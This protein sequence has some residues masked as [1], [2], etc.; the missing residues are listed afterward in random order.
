[1]SAP[2]DHSTANIADQVDKG[3]KVESITRPSEPDEL[4]R[5]QMSAYVDFV[6]G[7]AEKASD[8]LKAEI[9]KE[10]SGGKGSY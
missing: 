1:M 5:K 6:D 4:Q 3:E 9:E 8:Q 10:G 2:N 7:Q